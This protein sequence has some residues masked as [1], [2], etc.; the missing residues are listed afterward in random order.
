M[1]QI[2]QCPRC[3]S[4]RLIP[5]VRIVDRGDYNSARD[6]SVEVYEKPDALIFKGTHPGELK[7]TICADCGN[8]E[9]TVTNASDLYETFLK[10]QLNQQQT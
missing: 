8:A 1:K 6:L 2:K 3:N 4:D 9:L 10:A 7:A 5:D